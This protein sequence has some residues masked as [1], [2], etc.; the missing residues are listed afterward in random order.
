V[1]TRLIDAR[2]LAT[3]LQVSFSHAADATDRAVM[4]DSD[5]ASTRFAREAD[6]AAA[7]IE[8][9]S[10]SIEPL[11]QSL[12]Y[13]E[14]LK[15]LGDFR[16]AF[17]KYRALDREILSLAVE[18]TNLKAQRLSFGPGYAAA[19]AIAVA[20]QPALSDNDGSV[21]AL[22]ESIVLAVREIEVLEGPHIAAAADATMGALEAQMNERAER[23]RRAL[24]DLRH[25]NV[26]ADGGEAA[27]ERFL[28][29]HRQLIALSRRNSNV[30]SL[31]LA[32]GQKRTLVVVC[33][34]EL[35]ALND[36]LAQHDFI[37]TR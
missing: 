25:R 7:G 23:A 32:L 31:A 11:I 34:D 17:T 10:N 15:L 27:L 12:R 18:N 35:R 24:A 28:E 14:E 1:I 37:A 33:E 26:A 4:A 9:E 6:D 5:E 13:G 16:N 20:L 19:N 22:A 30:R 8:R 36:R 3:D 2:R 29:L 21:R